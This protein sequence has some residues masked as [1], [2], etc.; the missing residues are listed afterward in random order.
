[1]ATK[2][3][4]IDWEKIEAEYRAGALSLGELE[5]QHGVSRQ[6]ITKR[7][8]KL[9]WSRNLAEK[10]RQEIESRLVAGP[11]AARNAAEI[12]DTAASRSVQVILDHRRLLGKLRKIAEGIADAVDTRLEA[13]KAGDAEA[14]GLAATFAI[15]GE[16]ES[17][18]DAME[19]SAR[20]AQR[21]VDLER[22][23]FGIDPRPGDPAQVN[24]TANVTI[25]D[26]PIEA[27]RAYQRIINGG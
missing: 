24:V 10:V 17:L 22:Q 20:T 16:R 27:A 23:A 19:K 5:R 8:N 15:I 13:A 25:P 3:R 26:D 2:K 18:A 7:A 14:P 11:V 21:L 12:V 4:I 1:M 6:A 9:G